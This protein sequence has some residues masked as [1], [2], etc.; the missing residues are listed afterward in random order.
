MADDHKVQQ[1]DPVKRLLQ[2]KRTILVNV[3]PGCTSRVQLLD[4]IINKPLK[5]AIKEQNLD[6]YVDGKPTVFDRS[7]LTTNL[8]SYA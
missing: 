7:V 6:A 4:A 5:N 2:S 8:I 3:I 1:T